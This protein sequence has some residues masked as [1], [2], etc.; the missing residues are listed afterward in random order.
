MFDRKPKDEKEATLEGIEEAVLD[1]RADMADDGII[2]IQNF[3]KQHLQQLL[4][5]HVQ[6]FAETFNEI[7]LNQWKQRH[8]E[9]LHALTSI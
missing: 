3:S 9:L 8:E 7:E 6:N 2:Q 5:S 4:T 1:Y